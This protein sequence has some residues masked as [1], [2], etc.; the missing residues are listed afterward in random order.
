MQQI[1]TVHAIYGSLIGATIT[2][3]FCIAICCCMHKKCKKANNPNVNEREIEK[4][5]RRRIKKKV[6][7]SDSDNSDSVNTLFNAREC[8]GADGGIE[9]D[10]IVQR[11]GKLKIDDNVENRLKESERRFWNFKNIIKANKAKDKKSSTGIEVETMHPLSPSVSSST[12]NPTY[13]EI[14]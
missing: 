10:S 11:I 4:K 12:S 14:F 8:M 7:D 6:K 13:E 5:K 1:R 9:L 2:C 3:A